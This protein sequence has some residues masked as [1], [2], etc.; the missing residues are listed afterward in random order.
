M[1]LVL[2]FSVEVVVVSSSL[3]SYAVESDWVRLSLGFEGVDVR[4]S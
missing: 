2:G 3:H 4:P 1:F